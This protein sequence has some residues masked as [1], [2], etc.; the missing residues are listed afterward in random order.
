MSLKAP[1]FQPCSNKTVGIQVI[2]KG[3]GGG[4]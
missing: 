3:N 2:Y 1:L 4:L